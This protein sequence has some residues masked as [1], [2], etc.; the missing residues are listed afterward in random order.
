MSVG[1]GAVVGDTLANMLAFVGYDVTKEYYI[2]DAGVQIDVLGKSVFLR[3]REALGD[4]IG[5][6]PPG[7]IPATIWC[8]WGRRW[9]KEF[10]RSLLQM[11]EDDACHCERQDHRGDDEP[12]PRGSGVAQRSPR[13]LF[14]ER[15]L[16]R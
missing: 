4:D 6:I 3:Y 13:G 14:S 10:G 2:N 5:E 9:L 8:R 15:T 7:F 16:H 12:D 1:R 11:P